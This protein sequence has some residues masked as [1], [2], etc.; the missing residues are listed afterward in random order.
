MIKL[1]RDAMKGKSYFRKLFTVHC[2]PPLN[3]PCELI[4]PPTPSYLKR[5]CRRQGCYFKGRMEGFTLIEIVMIIVV[6]SIAI[7][8]LLIVLGQGARQSVDAELQVSATNVGQAMMEEIKTKCWDET[9]V[10]G[11][12]CTGTVT[13]SAIGTD[14]A[15]G[16]ETRTAC[17]G[18][19]ATPYD[20]VDDYNGYLEPCSWGGPSYT[21]SVQV[22]Y[23]PSGS[24]DSITP[25]V[26]A[27]A[28]ATD[29]KRIQVTV[30]NSTLGSVVLVTLV[31]NY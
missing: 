23:V 20:D 22:C 16:T 4:T 18:T 13:P 30:S 3:P 21:T 6:V 11:G 29:F 17:T 19:S 7:P 8:T 26:T 1:Y 9:A 2:S 28:S 10:S 25:C 24:L 27:Q 31:G 15:P 14:G 5:G 12:A